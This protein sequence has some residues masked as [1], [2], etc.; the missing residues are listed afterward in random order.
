MHACTCILSYIP[1]K[2][3]TLPTS[4]LNNK[5]AVWLFFSWCSCLLSLLCLKSKAHSK[6]LVKQRAASSTKTSL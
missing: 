4:N 2:L 1:T 3:P 5:L 6:A